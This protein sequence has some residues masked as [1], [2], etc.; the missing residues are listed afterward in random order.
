VGLDDEQIKDYRGVVETVLKK[1]FKL[2]LAR[3]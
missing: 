2:K 3:G 1:L